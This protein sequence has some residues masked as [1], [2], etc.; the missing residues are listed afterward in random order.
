MHN[1]MEVSQVPRCTN[2]GTLGAPTLAFNEE[3][4]WGRIKKLRALMAEAKID[5][6]W[7]TSPE[8]VCWLHGY[9]TS[10]YKAQSPMRY[11]QCYGTAVH[12]DHDEF[13]FFGD[14]ANAGATAQFSISRDTRWLPSHEAVPNI[15]FIMKELESKGWLKG[16]VGMEFWSYLPNRAV[17]TMFEGAFRA[18]GANVVDA[19]ALTRRARRVKS[20]AEIA[21]IKEAVRICDIGHQALRDNIRPCMT[22]LELFGLVTAAMMAA[23][24]EFPALIPNFNSQQLVDG[25]LANGSHC[26]AGPRKIQAGDLLTADLCGVYNRYHGNVSRGYFLGDPPKKMVEHVKKAAGVFEIIKTEVK[27]G[28]TVADVNA[29]VR[30]YYEGVGLW[31][32]P[33]WVLGYELG[34][35]LPPDWVGDFYF[36]AKNTFNTMDTMYTDRVF[37]ENMVTN[38][39]SIFRTP[40][41][42]TL[43][44]GKDETHVLSKVAL[45]IFGV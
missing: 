23:G 5:M 25:E 15:D 18:R 19:T 34:L 36:N 42:D 12:V 43:V 33:G 26:M 39:E 6:L 24:G 45:Q 11:P 29:V 27:A 35:S 3:E 31:E 13:I 41:I 4:Y 44:Y 22:E 9:F 7:V 17:S 21:C 14:L 2:L 8:V 30:R 38:F 20:S 1:D 40:L 16:T 28:M 10:W 37:E 32:S